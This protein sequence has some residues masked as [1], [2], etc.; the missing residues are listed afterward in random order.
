MGRW[1]EAAT[2]GDEGMLGVQA[3]LA[4]DAIAPGDTLIQVP[5]TSA[6]GDARRRLPAAAGGTAGGSANSW[7]G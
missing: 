3:I 1:P 7:A 2:V 5:D 4:A 6:R